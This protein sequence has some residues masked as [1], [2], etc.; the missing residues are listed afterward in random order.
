MGNGALG[1]LAEGLQPLRESAGTTTPGGS[2][3]AQGATCSSDG[4]QV[5]MFTGFQ[6]QTTSLVRYSR[7]RMALYHPGHGYA[8]LAR[9]SA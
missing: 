8:T 5:Q 6:D 2:T 7:A 9:V 4:Q 1:L 3:G